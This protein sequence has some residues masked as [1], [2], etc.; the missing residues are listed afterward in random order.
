[1]CVFWF[2]RAFDAFVKFVFAVKQSRANIG[3]ETTPEHKVRL[4]NDIRKNCEYW[5]VSDIRISFSLSLLSCRDVMEIKTHSNSRR[6]R[7]TA[8]KNEIQKSPNDIIIAAEKY[9]RLVTSSWQVKKRAKLDFEQYY[10]ENEK[11]IWFWLSELCLQ[12]QD[13]NRSHFFSPLV[14][15]SA[16]K[17]AI[18]D[19]E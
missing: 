12:F 18:I 6:E 3:E 5:S 17:T 11:N 9:E 8:K 13:S 15:E 10:A 4:R 2:Q 16:T 14:R 19:S 1:M 7:E